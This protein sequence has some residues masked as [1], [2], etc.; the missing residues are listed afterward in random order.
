MSVAVTC[1]EDHVDA[2]SVR[3]LLDRPEGGPVEE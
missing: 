3:V 2:V 1:F